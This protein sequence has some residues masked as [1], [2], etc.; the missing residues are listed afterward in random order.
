MRDLQSS[1]DLS[2]LRL[3]LTDCGVIATEVD[4][5]RAAGYSA[6][7]VWRYFLDAFIIDLDALSLI[8]AELYGNLPSPEV[9]RPAAPAER[10]AAA[11]WHRRQAA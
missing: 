8:M 3:R 1:P 11:L 7:A 9:A 10:P 2:G 5:L 6:P 4:R